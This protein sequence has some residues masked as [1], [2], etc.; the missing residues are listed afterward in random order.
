MISK[1]RVLQGKA[2]F[3]LVELMIAMVIMSVGL[4]A[5]VQME[6]VSLRGGGYAR[7]RM[8]ALQIAR[9]VV[10]ELR[11]RG[12]E[13]VMFAG[14]GK[15][16]TGVLPNIE[17][18]AIDE[19]ASCAGLGMDDV[20]SMLSY[21]GNTISS[22]NDFTNSRLVNMD[23]LGPNVP[24]VIDAGSLETARA[25]YRV[26]YTATWVNLQGPS[27]G[28][29]LSAISH[30]IVH[31]MVYVS[32]DNKDHGRQDFSWQNSDADDFWKRNV[33]MIPVDLMRDYHW[34]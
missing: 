33:I 14:G 16:L 4:F 18:Q 28:G 3:T 23:G 30:D 19:P 17:A 1:P 29:G 27:G 22:G 26:H 32:W 2:G 20:H 25:I 12:L 9:G 8:E 21:G 34:S 6:L 10:E 7:E 5:I 24:Q 15:D 11:A 13:W 31:L